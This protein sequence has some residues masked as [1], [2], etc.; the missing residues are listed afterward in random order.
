LATRWSWHFH[1]EQTQVRFELVV[2]G[3]LRGVANNFIE[4]PQLCIQREL[5]KE[6][7][8]ELAGMTDLKR[9]KFDWFA[10]ARGL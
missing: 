10:N 6:R 5:H 8:D 7:F 4:S 3:I 2:G 9:F 1:V